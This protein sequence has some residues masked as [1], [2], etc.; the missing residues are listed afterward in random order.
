[1]KKY[2]YVIVGIVLVIVACILVV[3]FKKDNSEELIVRNKDFLY[4]GSYNDE[5]DITEYYVIT[6]Y[7]DFINTFDSDIIK[8]ENF[9]TNNYVVVPIRYDSCTD[10]N[11]TPTDYTIK[12]NKINITVK[13]EANCGVCAP[14]YMYYVLK[15]DKSITSAIVD[16]NYK[17]INN[18]HC[19]PYISY[20]PLIYLYPEKE[21]NVIVKL[22]Y[23]NLLTTTYPKYTNEWNVVAK[24]NGELIDKSGRTYYGL[25]WE[26]INNIKEDFK[27]GFIV[28]KDELLTFLE[29]KLSV[30]GL[31]EREANEFIIYWLPKLEEN[32]YNLIRFED[33]ETVNK[34][35]PLTISPAPDTVIR[36]FMVYKPV[37]S[38]INITEQKLETPVRNGF[39]VV[40]WGGSLIK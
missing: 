31:T 14:A 12:D 30:L 8:E 17:A 3:I 33:M 27:D 2:V 37:D 20:K 35:M 15:V 23:P 18:P 29:E 6:N 40:E 22:G 5:L 16:I 10:K 26:A 9:N 32:E 34:E 21:E 4:L 13:Y 7:E 36:V 11:V 25:Y 1:M 19:D 38:K 28:S 39:T 24:P